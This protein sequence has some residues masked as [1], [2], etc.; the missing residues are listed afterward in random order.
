MTP[1]PEK[2]TREPDEILTLQEIAEHLKVSTRT[3]LRMVDRGDLEAGK[4]SRQWR[5][6]RTAID[7]LMTMREYSASSDDLVGVIGSKKKGLRGIPDIIT[8]ERIIMD[9]QPASKEDILRRL[10]RSLV[11][12]GTVDDGEAYF[13]R[14]AERE[15]MVSTA[16][17]DGV[18][19]PHARVPERVGPKQIAMVLGICPEG[20]DFDA[21]DGRLTHVFMLI[22]A[23]DVESHLRCLAKATLLLRDAERRGR[24][25]L[26]GTKQEVREILIEAHIDLSIRL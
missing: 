19:F 15:A 16:I 17:E 3:I 24:L 20:T 22:C 8:P 23:V 4:V 5:F 11:E 12:D 9:M 10:V 26:A 6:R 25:L 1:P 18:A 21:L 7:A 14:L 13:L 2:P